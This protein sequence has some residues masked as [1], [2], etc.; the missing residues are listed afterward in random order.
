M[1]LESAAHAA[2]LCDRGTID[3]L[4]YWPGPWDTFFAEIGTTLDRELARYDAVV[5]L[6]VPDA[7][8]GY[9]ASA[10]RI[11]S[12]RE[13][14]EIDARLLEVWSKHPSRIVIDAG[15]DFLLKARQAM[16]AIR[17][18]LPPACCAPVPSVHGQ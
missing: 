5:H 6:R 14:R 9:H 15:A 18:R 4:A 11:E 17:Q 16:S 13:A 1:A 12:P 2:I 10:L 7:T 8:N 3:G